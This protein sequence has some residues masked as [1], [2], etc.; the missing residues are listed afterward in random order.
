MKLV[1]DLQGAQAI[2]SKRG[3]GRYSKAIVSEICSK[4]SH[5]LDIHLMLN[6]AFLSEGLTLKNNFKAL[7]PKANFH[8][9]F[10]STD[11]SEKLMTLKERE[12]TCVVR[13]ALL[14]HIKPDVVFITSLFEGMIDNAVVSP[15]NLNSSYKTVVILYDL[16]PLLHPDSYLKT[17]HSKI[18]YKDR[19]K[20]LKQIDCILTISEYSK[21]IAKKHLNISEKKLF[22]ISGA[23]DHG[24]FSFSK[25]VRREN[26]IFSVSGMDPRKNLGFL[27]KSFSQSVSLLKNDF[28]LII[29]CHISPEAVKQFRALMKNLNL[30]DEQVVVNSVGNLLELMIN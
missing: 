13:E 24:V 30:K 12:R 26:F 8:T 6:G 2:N 15:Q 21:K 5:E 14:D 7:V 25:E 29:T 20:K 9:F 18:W 11:K 27:I 17:R 22:N 19:I 4:F 28:K 23:V 1:F 16:I 10:P 3:I